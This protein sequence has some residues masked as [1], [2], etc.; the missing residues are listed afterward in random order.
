MSNLISTWLWSKLTGV[1]LATVQAQSDA[2]DA[3]LAAKN[4]ADYQPGGTVYNNIAAQQGQQAADR[5]YKQVQVDDASSQTGDVTA[6]V[7]DA[8]DTQLSS[9]TSAI[10]S[11]S[12]S[13]ISGL[14]K[15]IFNVIP[16]QVWLIA[17]IAAFVWL[18]GLNL[19]RGAI[20][21]QK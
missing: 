21:K 7:G 11:A 18:G 8:F 9:E 13:F 12:S 1:D 2:A 3:A 20:H 17:G 5:A 6:Q 14:L 15:N 16:W 10:G 19:V 4:S